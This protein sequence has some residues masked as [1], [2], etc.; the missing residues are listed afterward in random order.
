MTAPDLDAAIEREA[1]HLAR[2]LQ[3]TTTLRDP[4]AWALEYWQERAG[5][6]WRYFE[7]HDALAH[8]AIG[9]EARRQATERGAALAR[10]LLN[11]RKD[12]DDA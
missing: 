5:R 11:I 7:Q 3:A 6:G 9:D 10:D 12:H 1:R 4:Y 8:H 2:L